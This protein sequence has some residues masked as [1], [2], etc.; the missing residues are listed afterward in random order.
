[1]NVKYKILIYSKGIVLQT[2]HEETE[3]SREEA[4]RIV[5]DS[6]LENCSVFKDIFIDQPQDVIVID[7]FHPQAQ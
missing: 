4:E 5:F 7:I 6:I 2:E 3:I 1:M